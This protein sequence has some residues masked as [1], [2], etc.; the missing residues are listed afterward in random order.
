[1]NFENMIKNQVERGE[2]NLKKDGDNPSLENSPFDSGPLEKDDGYLKKVG[3]S[4]EKNQ[5]QEELE[6]IKIKKVEES[7]EKILK[8]YASYEGRQEIPSQEEIEKYKETIFQEKEIIAKSL[9]EGGGLMKHIPLLIQSPFIKMEEGFDYSHPCYTEISNFVKEIIIEEKDQIAS[10]LQE[11]NWD[12]EWFYLDMIDNLM[13]YGD[14]NEKKEISSI[15]DKGINK[16]ILEGELQGKEMIDKKVSNKRRFKVRFKSLE[17]LLSFGNKESREWSN[18]TINETTGEEGESEFVQKNLPGYLLASHFDEPHKKGKEML[19]PFFDEYDLDIDKISQSWRRQNIKIENIRKNIKMIEELEKERP[20][21]TKYLLEEF[22]IANPAFHFKEMLIKQYEQKDDLEIPYGIVA[23][24]PYRHFFP[25]GLEEVLKINKVGGKSALS[26]LEEN[27]VATRIVEFSSSYDLIYHLLKLRN[28]YNPNEEEEKKTKF[29]IE[30]SHGRPEYLDNNLN[31]EER[32][33]KKNLKD[34]TEKEREKIKNLFSKSCDFA[35]FSCFV[36]TEGGLAQSW[37]SIVDGNVFA[38][39]EPIG[40]I[41][42]DV[43]VDKEK[44]VK[45]LVHNYGKEK[46]RIIKSNVY[47]K[48]K[49]ISEEGLK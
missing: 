5:H 10:K 26:K 4:F 12:N 15:I 46:G 29:F 9:Q 34:L 2:D 39:E 47:S 24:A 41:N 30:H 35:A 22:N 36:G 17:L 3:E 40:N 25:S 38:P 23:V 16:E 32:I 18:K 28:K 1:M 43:R 7:F 42:M 21:I 44:N 31:S 48:G 6:E 49:L 20:G 13:K 8:P 14:E 37:S 33:S 27:Q 19:Q 45:L 11:S